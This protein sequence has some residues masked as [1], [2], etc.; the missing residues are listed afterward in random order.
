ML[1]IENIKEKTWDELFSQ[2]CHLFEPR[3]SWWKS[4]IDIKKDYD[5]ILRRIA[6]SEFQKLCD[7]VD[8]LKK[9]VK[10]LEKF[11]RVLVTEESLIEV[12][13]NKYDEWWN[14]V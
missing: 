13:D 6:G 4:P 2:E 7:E 10:S 8:N 3:V 9:K 1:E 5:Q 12:W 11:Q 14:D